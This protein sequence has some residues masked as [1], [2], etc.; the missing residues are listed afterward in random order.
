MIEN[1]LKEVYREALRLHKVSWQKREEK[2]YFWQK[3]T[4]DDSHLPKGYDNP[5]CW[6]TINRKLEYSINPYSYNGN[7]FEAR[8][9]FEDCLILLLKPNVDNINYKQSY[10]IDLENYELGANTFKIEII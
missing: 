6:D 8:L 7:Q 10:D 3:S 2:K 1:K 4:F 9:S 5:N